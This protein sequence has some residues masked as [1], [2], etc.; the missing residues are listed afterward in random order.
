MLRDSP[1][2]LSRYV[3]LPNVALSER[4]AIPEH[5]LKLTLPALRASVVD[6]WLRG[7]C[8]PDPSYPDGQV[9]SIYFDSRD[10]LMLRAKVNGDFT[11][12][13]VR[14]RWYTDPASGV[15][16][17]PAFVEIKRKVGGRRF[18]QRVALDVPVAE[19]AAPCPDPAVLREA[20]GALRGAGILVAA[21]LQPFLRIGFRR[22]RFVDPTSGCRVS[23]DRD[24]RGSS[25]NPGLLP[26]S[27]RA[28]LA[29]AV[30]EVKGPHS[31]L[32]PWLAPLREIGCRPESFSK[33]ARCY[34]KII[35][36]SSL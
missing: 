6:A 7:R 24:I 15:P 8:L 1:S 27:N 16:L 5:E 23:I 34:L 22:G 30:V 10:M 32:S 36:R 21:D 14:V 13:K 28:P 18:K 33:Y 12:Q 2:P 3:P 35:R 31:A 20:L 11:K 17:G 4:P 25:V 29:H 19:L 9:T 26:L